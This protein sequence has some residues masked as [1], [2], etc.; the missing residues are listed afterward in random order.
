MGVRLGVEEKDGGRKEGEGK[1]MSGGE[2]VRLRR[3]KKES[4]RT[5]MKER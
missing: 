1:E 3:G 5:G 4:V 2:V